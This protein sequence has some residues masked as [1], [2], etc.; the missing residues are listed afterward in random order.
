MQNHVNPQL[1][2]LEVQTRMA[3]HEASLYPKRP[4]QDRRG[5]GVC[6]AVW[7]GAER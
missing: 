7:G 6:A 5:S 2:N 4:R 1:Q 3:P